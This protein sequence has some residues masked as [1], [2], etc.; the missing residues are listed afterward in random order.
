MTLDRLIDVCVLLGVW[1]NTYINIHNH[2][3]KK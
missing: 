1:I 2:R 3:K